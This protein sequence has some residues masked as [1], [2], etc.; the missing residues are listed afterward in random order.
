VPLDGGR[1][2][3]TAL[4]AA[5]ERARVSGPSLYLLSVLAPAAPTAGAS[6]QWRA[7]VQK[8]DRYLAA[9]R[10][11]IAAQTSSSVSSAVWSGSPAA[12]IVKAAELIDAELIV[13]ARSGRTG[14]PRQLVGSVVERVLRGTRCPVL[15]V[16]P[17]DASVD[18]S[19]GDA[20]PVPV[21]A[22]RATGSA[23]PV[24]GRRWP[25]GNPKQTSRRRSP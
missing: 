5:V 14:A 18:A 7:A 4:P 9:T 21:G 15:V 19:L 3:E 23:G 10:Q 20:A 25:S 16:T 6:L 2:A 17:A 24:A 1:A 13:M 8:A 11:R 22:A 12:A